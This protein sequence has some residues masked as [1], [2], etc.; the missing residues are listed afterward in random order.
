MGWCSRQVARV[1]LVMPFSLVE[2]YNPTNGTWRN[3]SFMISPREE[4][5]ATLL[6]NGQ[7]LVVGGY[8]NGALSSAEIYDPVR[9]LWRSAASMT[10]ARFQH[11][12]TLLPS[13]KVLVAGGYGTNAA[14]L[15]QAEIYDPASNLW[16]SANTMVTA[17]YIHTATLLANGQVLVTGG[18]GASDVLRSSEIFDP[19]SNSWTSTTGSMSNARRYHTA[20][21]LPNGKVLA[22]AGFNDHTGELGT[23]EIRNPPPKHDP[24]GPWPVHCRSTPRVMPIRRHCCPAAEVVV[25][26]GYNAGQLTRAQ[27]C[28]IRHREHGLTEFR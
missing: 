1:A 24:T 14:P 13:G 4:H 2:S 28:M 7:V 25:A 17:R 19:T 6:P 18:L 12:A 10:F 23:A 21:L 3:E 20:T 8:N 26:G 16:N 15:A 27:S 9:G 11:T 22:V 5:T